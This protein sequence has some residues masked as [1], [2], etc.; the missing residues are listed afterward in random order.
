MLSVGC[1][2]PRLRPPRRRAGR[3]DGSLCQRLNVT[4]AAA[5]SQNVS[6]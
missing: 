2:A 4:T 6:Y 3:T 5:A 1:L